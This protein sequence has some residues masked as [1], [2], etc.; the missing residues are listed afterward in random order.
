V[1][2]RWQ[3]RRCGGVLWL[4][5]SITSLRRLLDLGFEQLDLNVIS[6]HHLA[7]ENGYVEREA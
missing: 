6:F 2:Y 7:E 4:Y 1:K 5:F 3:E